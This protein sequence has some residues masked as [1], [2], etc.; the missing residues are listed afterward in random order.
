MVYYRNACII[1]VV[2]F[3]YP[4]TAYRSLEEIDAIFRKTK[5]WF[6]VVGTARDMPRRYG[7]KGELLI[8][9]ENTEEHAA[10]NRNVVSGH[11]ETGVFSAEEGTTGVNKS[12]EVSS[13]T[14]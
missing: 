4:E 13:V 11:V 12:S 14:K 6:D 3:F 9:Y 2:Y 5:G 10:R 7:E 1:P 8:E